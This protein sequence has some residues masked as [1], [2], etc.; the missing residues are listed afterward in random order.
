M[1]TTRPDN[2]WPESWERMSK[3][4]KTKNIADWAITKKI[5]DEERKKRGITHVKDN[6][7]DRY[8]SIL[9][10]ARNRLAVPDAPELPSQA[11]TA[12]TMV[13]EGREQNNTQ[14]PH[15]EHVAAAGFASDEWFAMV[16]TPVPMNEVN[17]T[18]AA[19]K[20]MEKEW[21]KLENPKNPN[22]SGVR[23][24]TP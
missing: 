19:V 3:Q 16:H 13:R 17:R 20:A 24:R 12:N 6:D 8:T 14:Q 2:V 21:T 11:G 23:R 22:C 1:T 7:V 4:M 9:A 10:D 15:H 5:R 18:P